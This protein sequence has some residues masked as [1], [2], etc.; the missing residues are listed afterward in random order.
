MCSAMKKKIIGGSS[1]KN[2]S[3]SLVILRSFRFY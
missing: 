2:S 3:F 1:L